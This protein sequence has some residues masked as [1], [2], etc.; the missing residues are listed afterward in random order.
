M[1][2][3][4][5]RKFIDSLDGEKGLPETYIFLTPDEDVFQEGD[6]LA[7][8]ISIEIGIQ[9]EPV[10][11][12]AFW[13]TKVFG[14]ARRRAESRQ[15]P[16]LTEKVKELVRDAMESQK[17]YSD[18]LATGVMNAEG[19]HWHAFRALCEPKKDSKEVKP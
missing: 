14:C 4:H 8:F 19:H 15:I 11:N 12:S 13:G 1:N 7:N 9:F 17:R 3:E 18:Y 2:A 10:H 16:D 6:E 5:W